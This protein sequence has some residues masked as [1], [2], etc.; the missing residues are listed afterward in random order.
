[1]LGG[2]GVAVGSGAGEA[3]AVGVGFGLAIPGAVENASAQQAAAARNAGKRI[4]FKA[5]VL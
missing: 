2:S 4:R 5:I 3:D 1:M